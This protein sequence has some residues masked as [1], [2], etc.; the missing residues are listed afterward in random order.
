M[1]FMQRHE[2]SVRK[3]YDS[4]PVKRRAIVYTSTFPNLRLGKPLALTIQVF[5]TWKGFPK[6]NC[7][8]FLPESDGGLKLTTT[9]TQNKNREGWLPIDYI[10]FARA[11]FGEKRTFQCCSPTNEY[12][13]VFYLLSKTIH[14]PTFKKCQRSTYSGFDLALHLMVLMSRKSPAR[15][16]TCARARDFLAIF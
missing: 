5:T 6:D 1:P 10:S 4:I 14:K 11:C 8:S 15:H 16:G 9:T 7:P 12:F 13:E 3:A 2:P